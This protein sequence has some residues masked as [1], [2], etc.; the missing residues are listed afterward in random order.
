M[1][2][3]PQTIITVVDGHFDDIYFVY[4]AADNEQKEGDEI[5]EVEEQCQTLRRGG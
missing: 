3:K 2:T 4:H 5:E 1:V